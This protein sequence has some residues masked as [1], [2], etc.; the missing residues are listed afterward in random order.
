MHV[1]QV[2]HFW[3]T[4]V[5]SVCLSFSGYICNP[6][7]AADFTTKSL[8]P[9]FQILISELDEISLHFSNL[10]LSLVTEMVKECACNEGD[11][12]SIPGRGRCLKQE[13]ATHSSILAW[14]I[15]WTEEPRGLQSTGSQRVGH[16]WATNCSN[17]QLAE[18]Q[19]QELQTTKIWV[20][21]LLHRRVVRKKAQSHIQ[22]SNSSC[23]SAFC[24]SSPLHFSHLIRATD[25][26][27]KY[28]YPPL[29]DEKVEI[30]RCF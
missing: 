12:G 26:Q 1:A 13:M 5:L 23:L 14:R 3:Q 4:F 22:K 25:L 9:G 19:P 15:P 20:L 28:C 11:L 8:E 30:Q 27:W 18:N 16:E 2:N 21:T 29:T 7:T 10:Q 24:V 17:L 6:K